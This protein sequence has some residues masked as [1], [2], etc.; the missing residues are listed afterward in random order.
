MVSW[1]V[2]HAIAI[3]IA[4]LAI[5]VVGALIKGIFFKPWE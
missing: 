4:G 5:I 2:D 3:G 1:I